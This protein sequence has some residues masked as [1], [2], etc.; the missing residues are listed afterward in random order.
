MNTQEL[1]KYINRVLGNKIRCLLPSFWWKK[2]FG[3]VVNAVESVEK[4]VNS[5]SKSTRELSTRISEIEENS[6]NS[7]FIIDI[8]YEELYRKR[9]NELLIPGQS[10]RITDYECTINDNDPDIIAL[11]KD[12]DRF[13]GFGIVVTALTKTQLSDNAS[14]TINPKWMTYGFRNESSWEVKYTLENNIEKYPWAREEHIEYDILVITTEGEYLPFFWDN[15]FSMYVDEYAHIGKNYLV[16]SLSDNTAMSKTQFNLN[17]T[18]YVRYYNRTV[19]ATIIYTKEMKDN[20]DGVLVTLS[21]RVSS[22][23]YNTK[24]YIWDDNKNAYIFTTASGYDALC[25]RSSNS[26][27]EKRNSFLKSEQFSVASVNNGSISRT[28]NG[29]SVGFYIPR[30]KGVVYYM[31]D[32]NNNEAFYDFKNILFKFSDDEP[33]FTFNTR[34]T[35]N[36]VEMNMDASE[37]NAKNN[38]IGKGYTINKVVFNKGSISNVVVSGNV[39]NQNISASDC[40]DN[41]YIGLNSEGNIRIINIYDN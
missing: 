20:G 6:F 3:E 29:I 26:F 30:G 22:A 36:G 32:H 15:Y 37:R 4:H 13:N 14:A 40:K 10:Y 31:K 18:V 39:N 21:S 28:I 16:N 9:E 11:D 19:E 2:L 34:G 38:K 41:S 24:P 25:Y 27:V 8:T 5:V 17:D 1:K 12:D 33:K 35:Y 7:S 23:K